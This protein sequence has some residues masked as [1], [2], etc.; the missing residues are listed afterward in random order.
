MLHGL[1]AQVGRHRLP[2]GVCST[3]SCGLPSV[4]DTKDARTKIFM[5]HKSKRR[6]PTVSRERCKIVRTPCERAREREGGEE[7]ERHR[8]SYSQIYGRVVRE[9]LKRICYQHGNGLVYE[10]DEKFARKFARLLAESRNRGINRR[11]IL[12]AQDRDISRN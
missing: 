2:P 5:L 3:R 1:F 6:A 8:A 12:V 9:S 11:G 10:D 4:V 7:T